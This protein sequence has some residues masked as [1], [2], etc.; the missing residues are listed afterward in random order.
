MKLNLIINYKLSLL[1]VNNFKYPVHKG[2]FIFFLH[3]PF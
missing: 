2:K 1:N 3:K